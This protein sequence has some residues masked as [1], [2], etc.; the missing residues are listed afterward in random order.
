MERTASFGYW[1]RRRR[2]AL[3]LTQDELA[4]QVGCARGHD[5][6]DRSRRAPALAPVCR[7]PGRLLELAP[8]ERA[9]SSRPRG[10]SWRPTSL[11]SLHSRSSRRAAEPPSRAA[12]AGTVTFLFTDIEGSTQLWEQQPQAMPAALARHDAMLRAT[13]AAHGG[14]VFKTVGDAFPPP[15]P[16][17]RM[18]WAPPWPAS[19]RWPPKRGARPARCACAWRCTAAPPSCATATTSARRSTAS[20]GCWPPAMAARS[21][22]RWRRGSWC[23]TTCRPMWR[24]ATWARIASRDLA[25][26]E[27]IFQLV[28]PDL[29]ADFPPLKTLDAP[30]QPAGAAHRLDRAR[31]RDRGAARPAAP[32][33][34]AP[35]HA[36]RPRRHRQDPPGLQVAAELLL[37]DASARRG[38]WFVVARADQRSGPGRR[39]DRAG[40]GRARGRRP[41]APGAA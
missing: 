8:D 28:A 35:G 7:A 10:P 3:D 2:K 34:R 6:E 39:D 25:R 27:Q 17:R 26:P 13:I 15:S 31:A 37:D 9:A 22:S 5:Q 30:H 16:P 21:C 38:V 40:A 29:P 23:A 18:R 1:L 11:R 4:H 36:H 33:R 14:D 41:A 32:R 12:P 24:C 20:R 19:A